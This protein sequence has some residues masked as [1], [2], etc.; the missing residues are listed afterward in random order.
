MKKVF[1]FWLLLLSHH[2]HCKVFSLLPLSV[3]SATSTSDTRASWGFTCDRSTA[4]SPTPRLSTGGLRPRPLPPPSESQK[5]CMFDCLVFTFEGFFLLVKERFFS[6]HFVFDAC[7][8][9]WVPF[10]VFKIVRGGALAVNVEQEECTFFFKMWI[11]ALV[12]EEN[13][14]IE[15]GSNLSSPLGSLLHFLFE[16]SLSWICLATQL[17]RIVVVVREPHLQAGY[18]KPFFFSTSAVGNFRATVFCLVTV[19][20]TY[21]Y[22]YTFVM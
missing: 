21:D 12:S 2:H 10:G 4:P 7:S 19:C 13:V 8:V 22:M 20:A 14:S 6:A 18:E 1:F 5:L 15:G 3:K 17:Q 9:V 16:M 11:S